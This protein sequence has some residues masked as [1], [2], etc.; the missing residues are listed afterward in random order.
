MIA[1]IFLSLT[2]IEF[3]VYVFLHKKEKS[4]V[5]N[6]K[7]NFA[8]DKITILGFIFFLN[9]ALSLFIFWL[10]KTLQFFEFL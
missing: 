2:L 8:D 1:L 10:Y 4:W 9:F 3:F 5:Y 6:M 7:R